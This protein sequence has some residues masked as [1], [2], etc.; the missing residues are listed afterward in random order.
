MEIGR[1][2]GPLVRVVGPET[3]RSFQT[4]GPLPELVLAGDEVTY[5]VLYDDVGI[6]VGAMRFVDSELTTACRQH[7]KQLFAAG[8]DIRT[9]LQ[10][11]VAPLP[12]PR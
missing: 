3:A 5:E 4:H 2:A 7:L 11:G 12:P 8:E 10:R 6:A 1:G 9:F